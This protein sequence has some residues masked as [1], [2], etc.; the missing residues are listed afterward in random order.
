M[1]ARAPAK[2]P[3]EDD[4]EEEEEEAEVSDKEEDEFCNKKGASVAKKNGGRNQM[5]NKNHVPKI[6]QN[7]KNGFKNKVSA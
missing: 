1:S 7:S 4:D 2:I 3:E 6:N 5:V